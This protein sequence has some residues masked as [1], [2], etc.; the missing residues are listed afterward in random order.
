MS[1]DNNRPSEIYD[2]EGFGML[3]ETKDYNFLRTLLKKRPAACLG[4]YA[5]PLSQYY[6]EYRSLSNFLW[7]VRFEYAWR[8]SEVEQKRKKI[9]QVKD[10]R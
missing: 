2:N 8:K 10:E 3:S 7:F 6:A 1:N 5:D 9:R 4:F